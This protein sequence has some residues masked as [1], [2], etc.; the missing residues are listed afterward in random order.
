MRG[1]N[2]R[3]VPRNVQPWLVLLTHMKAGDAAWP[4]CASQAESR[5]SRLQMDCPFKCTL[6]WLN[7]NVPLIS[8]SLANFPP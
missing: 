1:N 5:S 7:Q 4:G 8:F 6:A 2:Q 3:V